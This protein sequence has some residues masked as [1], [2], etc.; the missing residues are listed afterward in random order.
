MTSRR[1]YLTIAQLEEFADI[2]VTNN[3]EA[4]DRISMAE[5]LIDAYV[6]SQDKAFRSE[7]RGEVTGVSGTTIY[8]TYAGSGFNAI[9]NT[10][11][12]CML[13]IVGGAGS[14]QS[15]RI[16]SSNRTAS[17]VTIEAA[18]TVQPN[19]TSVYRVY[20][21]AK[22]PRQKDVSWNRLGTALY[23]IIP[24]A[25]QRATA[26]QVAFMIEMGDS[27]F[28]NS[29]SDFQSENFLNYSYARGTGADGQ[30]SVVKLLAPRARTLLR[31]ITNRKGTIR[32]GV[33]DV[34][35]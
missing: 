31:G 3:A 19:T 32:P 4:Y 12:G 6:G 16:I 1:N 11:Q 28:S 8:D 22:F 2:T 15:A 29:N 24:E 27:Y 18:F 21:L 17:S 30:S 5:E 13:E 26:A 14:G 10:Y 23:K 33:P 7:L 34:G 9:D 25:V 20:Q 35:W